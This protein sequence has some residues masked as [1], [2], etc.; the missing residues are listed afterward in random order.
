MLQ[1]L[2][3]RVNKLLCDIMSDFINLKHVRDCNPFAIDIHNVRL[4]VP[5]NQVYVG[6]HATET[7]SNFPISSDTEGIKK[8]KQCC[9]AFLIELVEQIRSRFRTNPFKM[10]EFLK[11]ENALSRNP[12]SLGEVFAA[13]PYLGKICDKSV[14]DIE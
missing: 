1:Y 6:V 14:A 10:L 4:R 5:I 8:F 13:L 3:G 12:N 9:R 7:L 11:S 2:H